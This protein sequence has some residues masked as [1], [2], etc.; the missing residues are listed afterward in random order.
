MRNLLIVLAVLLSLGC[1]YRPIPTA[2]ESVYLHN[3]SNNVAVCEYNFYN[4]GPLYYSQ[5]VA[6]DSIGD[7]NCYRVID[8]YVTTHECFIDYCYY[9]DTC[10][11]EVYD[12]ICY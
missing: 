11:W 2:R 6:W 8:P 1:E 7:C 5:C 9:W 10:Q 12:S 3:Y 4:R